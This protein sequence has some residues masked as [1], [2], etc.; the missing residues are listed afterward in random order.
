MSTA[1]YWTTTVLEPGEDALKTTSTSVVSRMPAFAETQA[2][3]S[4]TA[5][6]FSLSTEISS[7]AQT[8]QVC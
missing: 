5:R 2:A 6:M 1:P 7:R 3:D 4:G 8:D